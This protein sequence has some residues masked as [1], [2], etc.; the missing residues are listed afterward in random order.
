M[1]LPSRLV[2]HNDGKKYMELEI[3]ETTPMETPFED[4]VFAKPE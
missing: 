3:T 1:K 2:L 4:S